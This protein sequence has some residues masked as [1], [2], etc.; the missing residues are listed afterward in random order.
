VPD[1]YAHEMA[2]KQHSTLLRTLQECEGAVMI[3][4]YPN[5]LYDKALSNWNRHDF[6][7]DNKASGAKVKP[8][9]TECVWCNF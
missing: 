9:V 1:A 5:Q 2:P 6:A 3:S 8:Q 4:G 7:I